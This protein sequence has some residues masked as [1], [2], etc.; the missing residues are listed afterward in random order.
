MFHVW[1]RLWIICNY[2]TFAWLGLGCCWLL[3]IIFIFERN[4]ECSREARS[5]LRSVPGSEPL[6]LTHCSGV[7]LVPVGADAVTH[8]WDTNINTRDLPLP[9]LWLGLCCWGWFGLSLSLCINV[10]LVIRWF[11]LRFRF[12]LTVFRGVSKLEWSWWRFL[13][14]DWELLTWTSQTLRSP[15][16]SNPGGGLGLHHYLN[17]LNLLQ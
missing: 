3:R 11:T 2:L 7:S 10:I 1:W 9:S 4:G 12:T 17:L 14:Q 16:Q 8:V 6:S 5:V 15:A 13:G